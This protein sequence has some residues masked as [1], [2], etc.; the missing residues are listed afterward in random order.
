MDKHQC[1]RDNIALF[2]LNRSSKGKLER[3]GFFLHGKDGKSLAWAF[4][5]RFSLLAWFALRDE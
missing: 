3:S 1:S 4:R 2:V 5:C